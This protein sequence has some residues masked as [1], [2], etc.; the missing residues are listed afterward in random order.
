MSNQGAP[1]RTVGDAK[2]DPNT[3]IANSK[4]PFAGAR[5]MARPSFATLQSVPKTV[6]D[7]V[8]RF[9]ADT[10]RM[11]VHENWRAHITL[12]R[13][14]T[15]FQAERLGQPRFAELLRKLNLPKRSR[16]FTQHRV[17]AENTVRLLVYADKLPDDIHTLCQLAK[18]EQDVLHDF[19]LSRG[20]FTAMTLEEFWLQRE[21]RKHLLVA[22]KMTPTDRQLRASDH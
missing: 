22:Q 6:P 12:I 8:R 19:V 17:L 18:L 2:T 5:K 10:K 13:S 1:K 14:W 4:I 7:F 16:L 9:H 11:E 20:I 3:V 15:L 21:S